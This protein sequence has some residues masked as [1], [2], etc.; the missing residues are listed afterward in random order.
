M[1][2]IEA[3]PKWRRALWLALR[4]Y[5]GFCTL[6]FTVYLA[7]AVWCG[8]FAETPPGSDENTLAASFGRYMASEYPKREDAFMDVAEI[9]GLRC[10]AV[11]VLR[12]D[13]LKYLGRPDFTGGDGDASTLVYIFHPP[14]ETNE[15]EAYA[16]LKA[17]RLTQVGFNGAGQNDRSMWQPYHGEPVP[18]HQGGASTAQ[19]PSSE[20]NRTSAAAGSRHSP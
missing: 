13:V 3:K 12:T 4:I 14:G 5:A 7:F 16:I 17:G 10:K 19:P 11:P 6:I 9:L 2:T 20:T 15:S 1:P 18:N 8:F